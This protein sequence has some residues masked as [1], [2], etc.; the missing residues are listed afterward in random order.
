MPRE[1]S[2]DDLAREQAP[3]PTEPLG[4]TSVSI[5]TVKWWRDAKGYGVISVAQVAPWDVWCHFSSIEMEREDEFRTLIEGER[6]EVEYW[7]A[8]QESFKYVAKRVRR[9]GRD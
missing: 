6:V 1:K 7:R 2:A 8:D 9:L 4:T 5:G 3:L